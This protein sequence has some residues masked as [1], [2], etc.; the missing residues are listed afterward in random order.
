MHASTCTRPQALVLTYACTYPMYIDIYIYIY[1][2]TNAY[3]CMLVHMQICMGDNIE[4]RKQVLD[5]DQNMRK[6]NM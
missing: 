6:K 3:V 4:R 2:Y 1:I 5:Y